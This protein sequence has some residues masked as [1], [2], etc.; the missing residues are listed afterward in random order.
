MAPV[1]GQNPVF[2]I[3]HSNVPIDRIIFLLKKSEIDVVADVRSMP[4]SRHV[5]QA[6][7][8][9]LE[10][11][12]KIEGIRY[13]FMGEQLG[14]RPM[15]IEIHDEWGNLDY[16]ELAASDSFHEGLKRIVK[17]SEQYNVCVLCS[18]EDP[19]R[20][21][22]GLLISRELAK[23]G[24]EVRHI[25]HDGKVDGQAGLEERIPLVQ[26]G[27]FDGFVDSTPRGCK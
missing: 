14:G 22:R 13:I 11:A 3:G 5:P 19:L 1:A 9:K 16:S 2:T 24:L 27:L 21:H 25:R 15:D 26:K 20:C 6:N 12:L 7:R 10:E 17:G 18:E 23:L 8:E 4:Y